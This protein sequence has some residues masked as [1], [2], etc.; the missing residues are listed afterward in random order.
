MVCALSAVVALLTGVSFAQMYRGKSAGLFQYKLPPM[1]VGWNI[2][3]TVIVKLTGVGVGVLIVNGVPIALYW[4]N[5]LT[6]A[7]F[8]PFDCLHAAKLGICRDVKEFS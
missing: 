6:L 1:V 5:L 8:N 3:I 4:S 7:I 2:F